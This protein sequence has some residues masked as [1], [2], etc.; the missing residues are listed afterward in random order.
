[1][2]RKLIC[3]WMELSGSGISPEPKAR[4]QSAS[5]YGVVLLACGSVIMYCNDNDSAESCGDVNHLHAGPNRGKHH[6][7]HRWP[8]QCRDVNLQLGRFGKIRASKKLSTQ[9]VTQRPHTTTA[10]ND[11]TPESEDERG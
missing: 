5:S 9:G 8:R 3:G 7:D 4:D 6:V 11:R 1:M 10:R 2:H